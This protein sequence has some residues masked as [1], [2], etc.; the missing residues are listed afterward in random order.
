[1]ST[2]IRKM[3][4]GI[5]KS[6]FLCIMEAENV[7]HLVHFYGGGIIKD[8]LRRSFLFSSLSEDEFNIA[9]STFCGEMR[10]FS[11]GEIIYSPD[12][13]ERKIGFVI[14]GQ[15]EVCRTRHD[16]GRVKLN[17]LSTGESFGIT[18]VFSKED[19]PTS[20]YAGRACEIFFITESELMLLIDRFP[21]VALSIIRFQN[22]RIAFLNK[23]I[24]TFSAGSVEERLATYILGEYK[25]YGEPELHLNRMKT[26][27]ILGVGRAS[28]YRALDSLASSGIISLDTKKIYITDLRGLERI[29]K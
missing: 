6:L 21:A 16:G 5:D 23:K 15:C 24:E 14:S 3:R 11:R 22:D 9:Y 19:F 8:I 7:Y 17:T 10:A 27:D 25:K 12:C 4:Q 26:A 18:A 29:V 13:Y 20:V 1:M 28:L 2:K